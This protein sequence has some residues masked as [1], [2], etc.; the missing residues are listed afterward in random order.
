MKR[1]AAFYWD[2]DSVREGRAPTAAFNQQNEQA[3]KGKDKEKMA[4]L[5]MELIQF[6]NMK[7]QCKTLKEA[8]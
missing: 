2:C 8:D 1:G 4:S 7:H 5:L 6:S 3:G